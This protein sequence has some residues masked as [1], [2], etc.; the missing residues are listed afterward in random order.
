MALP[1][2]SPDEQVF[3]DSVEKALDEIAPDSLESGDGGSGD[4][5]LLAMGLWSFAVPDDMGGGGGSAAAL[6][7]VVRAAGG[8]LTSGVLFSRM[9]ATALLTRCGAAE[10]VAKYTDRD[11]WVT[12]DLAFSLAAAAGVGPAAPVVATTTAG[13]RT[14]LDGSL[15]LVVHN[16]DADLFVVARHADSGG[17]WAVVPAGHPGVTVE[18]FPTVDP[19]RRF[20]VVR[21]R[22]VEVGPTDGGPLSHETVVTL[23][24][25]S[26]MLV[27]MDSIGA[28]QT[29]LDRTVEYVMQREQFG[30]PIGLFQ[31]VQHKCAD[32][33]I[34]V[35]S[36]HTATRLVLE[37][38]D[39]GGPDLPEALAIH[40][41]TV[42][43]AVHAV[44]LSIQLHGGIGFTW[45]HGQHLLLR[46]C[47]VNADL[48]LA[49]ASRRDFLTRS[50]L[51]AGRRETT[52][53]RPTTSREERRH[54]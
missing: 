1:L 53:A 4:P 17:F 48:I 16:A 7:E 29:A 50:A 33:L 8:R 49:A 42:Q 52:G 36:A 21:L 39:G 40:G 47:H 23:L 25:L 45:E 34:D 2:A 41:Y 28:A 27:S 6:G 14:V 18:E 51:D 3:V 20:D 26:A 37:A 22:G 54:E 31:A 15:D 12:T 46:R 38:F 5:R 32:M 30:S 10:H 35:R 44:E 43:A 9:L 13:S 19:T 24:A 11:D